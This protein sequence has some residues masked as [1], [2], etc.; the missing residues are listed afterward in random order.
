MRELT[1]ASRAIVSA[2]LA[3]AVALHF[4]WAGFGFP[5]PLQLAALHLMLFVPPVFVL[6]PARARDLASPPGVTDWILAALAVLPGLYAYL[7]YGDVYARSTFITPLPEVVKLLGTLMVLLVLEA[8]RRALSIVLALLAVVALAY[9]WFCDLLPGMW[10]YRNLP[11]N[12]IVE[13]QYWM[14]DSAMFGSLT[15]ICASLIAA[16]LIFGAVMQTS[17]MGRLFTNFGA[18]IAGNYSGGPAKVAVISS[19]LFG[20]MSGSS[21]ANVVVSGSITIPMM[22]RIGFTPALA[23]GI[24]AAASVGGPL[25]PPL[26]GAAAFV[27][28]ETTGIPYLTIIG[29]AAL[30]AVIYYAALLINVHFEAK[31]HGIAAIPAEEMPRRRD[32]LADLHLVIPLAVLV[33]MLLA[34]FSPYMA[35]FWCTLLTIAVS[36][37]RRHTR[38]GPARILAAMVSAGQTICIVAVSVAAA[39]IITAALTQT[40]L[41]L[42]ITGIIRTV[43]GDS[44]PA[45][46]VLIALACLVMGMGIPTTP[47][48]IITA[49]IGA[50][51]LVEHGV[52]LLDAHLFVFYF[53]VLADVTPPVAGATY[54]AAAIGKAPPLRAGFQAFRLA[55]GGFLCGIAVCFD[56]AL[57]LGGSLADTVAITVALVTGITLISAGIVGWFE[58][59]LHALMRPVLILLGL[60][61]GLGYVV[62]SWER[63]ILGLVVV[64][65]LALLALRLRRPAQSPSPLKDPA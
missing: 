63:A 24:E 35:A 7:H 11:L 36:W 15:R 51:L 33:F 22:K 31:R 3:G 43:A 57:T 26:M 49:A 4:Y 52:P 60:F 38:M 16:F 62:P 59:R 56:H 27:M 14:V 20:T 50:P 45:L 61:C 29:S 17:G 28:S 55:I 5:E 54:A 58:T 25:M 53:A 21:V 6:F 34:Q 42:A 65:V 37:L 40:G 10:H 44:F 30:I 41:V 19:G 8:V 64:G 46:V 47:A 13:I 39:G 1:G 2:W 48:Y 12:Q 32:I 9:L 23:S 18:R